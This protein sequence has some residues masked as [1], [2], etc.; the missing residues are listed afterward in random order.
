LGGRKDVH[1]IVLAIEKLQRHAPLLKK[2]E[3]TAREQE[4][5]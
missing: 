1:D 4:S 3:T 5:E 2:P